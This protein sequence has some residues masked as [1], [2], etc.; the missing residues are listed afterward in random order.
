MKRLESI[1]QVGEIVQAS[2]T[3]PQLIFKHSTRCSIS[4]AAKHRL[5]ADLAAL[6]VQMDVHFLDLLAHKDISAI[7]ADRFGVRHESPQVILIDKGQ[8][9]LHLSHYDIE[10]TRI[11][12]ATS[13]QEQRKGGGSHW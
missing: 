6:N 13:S 3:K 4:A 8:V 2:A 1:S 11:L 9:A 5:D 10:S 7:V 12:K